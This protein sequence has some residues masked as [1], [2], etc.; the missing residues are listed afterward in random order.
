MVFRAASAG[1]QIGGEPHSSGSHGGL[2]YISQTEK[3]LARRDVRQHFGIGKTGRSAVRRTF[4]APLR[5]ELRL[6]PVPR[7]TVPVNSAALATFA[8]TGESEVELT[9]WMT[10]HLAVHVWTPP[11]DRVTLAEVERGV[12]ADLNPPLNLTRRS[13]AP[14][15]SGEGGDSSG[16]TVIRGPRA[17]RQSRA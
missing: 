6:L 15:E 1:H 2:L 10:E 8:L 4:A 7:A 12:I 3:S 16:P 11:S 14:P 17:W 13:A 5:D 9:G